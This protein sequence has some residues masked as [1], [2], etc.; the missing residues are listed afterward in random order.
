MDIV[1]EVE[2]AGPGAYHG[3]VTSVGIAGQAGPEGFCQTLT[4]PE[5]LGRVLE[6]HPAATLHAWRPDV[7]KKVLR[8]APWGAGIGHLS[9]ISEAAFD[10]MPDDRLPTLRE[11]L[12]YFGLPADHLK[13]ARDRALAA[14]GVLREVRKRSLSDQS[15]LSEARHL[16]DDGF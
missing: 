6:S 13:D 8:D 7:V 3:P 12:L 2:T 1:L 9:S 11:A 10:L 5:E 14:L 4:K 15:F 16:M